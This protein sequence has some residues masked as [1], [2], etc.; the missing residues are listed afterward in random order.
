MKLFLLEV[1]SKHG[2]LADIVQKVGDVQCAW[3]LLLY[4]VNTRA[5]YYCRTIPPNQSSDF[6]L[7]HVQKLWQC[8]G[9]IL[10]IDTQ[11]IGE[12]WRILGPLPFSK[13]GISLRSAFETR[14]A[15]YWASW[16]DYLEMVHQRH[17]DVAESVLGKFNRNEGA[18]A[19]CKIQLESLGCELPT[20]AECVEGKRPP[21]IEGSEDD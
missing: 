17:P 19:E 13:G 4:C 3:L 8:L 12:S 14:P 9:G 21:K 1:S 18:A 6:A 15:A 10:N 5:N 20:W 16:A 7:A 2:K 11:S